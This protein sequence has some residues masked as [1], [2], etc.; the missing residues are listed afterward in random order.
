MIL[1][2]EVF[3]HDWASDVREKYGLGIIDLHKSPGDDNFTGLCG[4]MPLNYGWPRHDIEGFAVER[5]MIDDTMLL[6]ADH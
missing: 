4:P 3:H 1:A 5:P 2:A 6:T